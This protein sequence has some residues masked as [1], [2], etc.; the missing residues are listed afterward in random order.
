[1]AISDDLPGVEV[2]ITQNGQALKEYLDDTL[3]EDERTVTRYIEAT[4]DENSELC[5][6]ATR[7]TAFDGD[8][9]GCRVEIDGQR[10]AEPL[11]EKSRT[12]SEDHIA[13]VEGIG[14]GGGTVKRF[15]FA[16]L[17]TG[18]L[19]DLAGSGMHG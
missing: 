18:V 2:S 13:I 12:K 9:M 16:C 17:E 10:I 6:K 3:T 19:G 4:S 15:K 14:I 1:M 11:L 5:L 7:G 8:C